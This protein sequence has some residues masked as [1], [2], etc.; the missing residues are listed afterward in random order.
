MKVTSGAAKGRTLAAVPG[1]GT[2]PVTD[3]VKQAV[4]NILMDDVRESRWLD[5]FA[6]TGAVGIEAL[7]RGAT[8]VTFIDA[9]AAA[10]RTIKANLEH[11]GLEPRARVIRQD[12]FRFLSVPPTMAYD[13]IYVAPPQ[14]QGLWLRALEALD[15]NPDWL[16]GTGAIIVQIDPREFRELTLQHLERV[17]QRKYGRTM[18]LFYERVVG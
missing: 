11:T 14:H 2:R 9:D 13:F 10:V 6:G 18:L 7:S 8:Q 17:D 16:D 1:A 15:Q 12:A 5:L 3:R 4:F